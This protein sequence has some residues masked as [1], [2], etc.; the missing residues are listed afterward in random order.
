MLLSPLGVSHLGVR[1]AFVRGLKYETYVQIW[2]R[3]LD[4]NHLPLVV[5]IKPAFHLQVDSIGED[6]VRLVLALQ[7]VRKM[8]RLVLII[9][10]MM[11][12]KIGNPTLQ[13]RSELGHQNSSS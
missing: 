2:M 10:P 9:N 8:D 4:G 3:L 13:R 12:E 11:L 6:E 1:D 7:D 5:W